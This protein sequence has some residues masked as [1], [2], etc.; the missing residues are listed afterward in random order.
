MTHSRECIGYHLLLD[1]FDIDQTFEKEMLL[2]MF[3]EAC[4]DAGATILFSKV[5]EFG[6]NCG[7]T[8]IIILAESHLSWHWYNE[9][10]SI[11]ID[12]FTCGNTNPKLAIP[13]ILIFLKPKKHE[14][15]IVMRGNL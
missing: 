3:Q 15:K 13:R 8:G 2:P 6:E 14:Q 10:R 7:T 12:L 4:I 11:Y 5:Q 9:Y 1:L